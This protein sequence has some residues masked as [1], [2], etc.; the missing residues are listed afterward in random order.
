MNN[1]LGSGLTTTVEPAQKEVMLDLVKAR[2]E[3]N[4]ARNGVGRDDSVPD[5]EI[6]IA[7]LKGTER[8]NSD[9]IPRSQ[10]VPT[11]KLLSR[12]GSDA[13]SKADSSGL[14][15]QLLSAVRAYEKFVRLGASQMGM[16]NLVSVLLDYA[17]NQK[18]SD[19]E[20]L[21]LYRKLDSNVIQSSSI[22]QACART[23]SNFGSALT[24]FM[25]H[26][27]EQKY[28]KQIAVIK[29]AAD[30]YTEGLKRHLKE[31]PKKLGSIELDSLAKEAA[32]V[33]FQKTFEACKEEAILKEDQK[34][35]LKYAL[36]MKA[37]A[38]FKF[39]TKFLL[40]ILENPK[41]ILGIAKD[42]LGGLTAKIAKDPK[43]SGFLHF[44]TDSV[45]HGLSLPDS[46]R[47]SLLA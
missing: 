27:L 21:K 3:T 46:G 8:I 23:M 1:V 41:E 36:K 47:T 34:A 26:A 12:K 7:D 22:E 29:L 33:Y 39:S 45:K 17:K 10:V 28:G 9:S 32:L 16:I 44:I 19:E 4:F 38:E 30:E 13:T 11:G 40:T 5:E 25:P 31:L 2:L 14:P 6:T 20:T 42:F 37:N 18:L 15:P 35:L 43:L 24:A